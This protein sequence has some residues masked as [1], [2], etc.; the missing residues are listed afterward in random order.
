MSAPTYEQLLSALEESTLQLGL[1]EGD[2]DAATRALRLA[3]ARLIAT[4]R[5][6]LTE[7]EPFQQITD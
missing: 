3:H 7:P 5:N 6:A 4:A 1:Y 2:F